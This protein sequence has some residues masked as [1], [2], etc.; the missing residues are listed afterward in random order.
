MVDKR[1]ETIDMSYDRYVC[2][3]KPLEYATI[4][5]KT[6]LSVFLALDSFLLFLQM[7]DSDSKHTT[8]V[9]VFGPVTLS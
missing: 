8:R 5:R 3:C 4:M 6:T 1:K 7:S 2:M 9:Q